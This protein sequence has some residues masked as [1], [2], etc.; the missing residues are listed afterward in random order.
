MISVCPYGTITLMNTSAITRRIGAVAACL[1]VVAESGQAIDNFKDLFEHEGGAPRSDFN[2][3]VSYSTPSDISRGST[4]LGDLDS[5]QSHV[6]YQWRFNSPTH[7]QWSVGLDWQRYGFGVPAGAPIPNSLQSLA[8][9][10]GVDWCFADGW[11]LRLQVAPGFY[12]D[13]QDLSGGDLNSPVTAALTYTVDPKLQIIGQFNADVRREFPVFAFVGV[14]WQFAERWTA[15]ALFPRPRVE[16]QATD[17]LALFAG[18][19][20]YGGAFRV[21]DDFGRTH[22]QT[23]LDNQIV[24]YREIRVGAGLRYR[25]GQRLSAELEG[26]WMIDRRFHYNDRHLLLNGDGAPYVGVFANLSF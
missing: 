5:L 23:N 17:A 26:G 20:F 11:N 22:G 14:R 24:N 15:L 16:Y 1:L 25:V 3:E 21:A 10:L 6:G 13:F 19:G 4:K 7:V 12:S 18:S 2:A 9:N 8:L